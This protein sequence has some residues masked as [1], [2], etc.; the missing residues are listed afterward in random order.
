M[1]QNLVLSST[2]QHQRTTAG[3]NKKGKKEKKAAGQ[4]RGTILQHLESQ[5]CK[6]IFFFFLHLFNFI[7]SLQLSYGSRGGEGEGGG[8]GGGGNEGCHR[9]K[10]KRKSLICGLFLFEPNDHFAMRSLA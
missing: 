2:N 7:I 4:K 3:D 9:G 8:G 1:S 10:E 5:G 6:N